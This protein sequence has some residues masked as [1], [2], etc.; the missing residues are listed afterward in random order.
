MEFLCIPLSQVPRTSKLHADFIEHF[1]QVKQW[2][3]H[4]PDEAGVIASAREARLDRA[5]RA[6]VVA[7]LREQNTALGSDA[8]VTQSLDRLANAAVAVV[9]G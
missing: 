4:S 1:P 9:T 2:Y 7:I 5:V 8:S 3:G 6:E